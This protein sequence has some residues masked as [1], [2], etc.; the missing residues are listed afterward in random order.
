MNNQDNNN[1]NQM[2][3][4]LLDIQER[5]DKIESDIETIK[6]SVSKMDDHVD[7][8][9]NVYDNVKE[10]FHNVISIANMIPRPFY[11]GLLGHNP[12]VERIDID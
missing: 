7:F 5:L 6:K 3:K 8:V 10:G 11:S 12:E 2:I 1:Y 4:I 9:N